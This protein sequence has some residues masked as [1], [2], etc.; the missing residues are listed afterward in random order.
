MVT[1]VKERYGVS[2]PKTPLITGGGVARIVVTIGVT[3]ATT[4]VM[5]GA[6]G[7]TTVV[8]MGATGAITVEIRG[9]TGATTVEISGATGATT[10][11]TTVVKGATTVDPTETDPT[12]RDPT[13]TVPPEVVVVPTETGPTVR[14]PV[15]SVPVVHPSFLRGFQQETAVERL[16]K[17]VSAVIK[18]ASRFSAWSTCAGNSTRG[19]SRSVVS[20]TATNAR[21]SP[22]RRR[23]Q[24]QRRSSRSD[25]EHSA[26]DRA[27][28]RVLKPRQS[29][30][31]SSPSLP[32][33]S[34]SLMPRLC[35]RGADG[36]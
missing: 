8:M 27:S 30:R 14:V 36:A 12:E 9:A 16:V 34:L 10:V 15:V 28:S 20:S 1:V 7:A 18:R 26:L 22:A 4:G 32:T 6:T 19:A 29:F 35:G 13:E 25:E 11:E 31:R 2:K 17:V 33:G 21:V 3:G 24:S 23:C 5:I